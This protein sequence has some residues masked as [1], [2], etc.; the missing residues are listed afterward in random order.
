M[1]RDRRWIKVTFLL[2]AL[3]AGCLLLGCG[4]TLGPGDG[5]I[6]WYQGFYILSSPESVYVRVELDFT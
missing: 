1:S 5:C 4:E 3:P 2:A 6:G